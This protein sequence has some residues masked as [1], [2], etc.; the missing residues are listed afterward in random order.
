MVDHALSCEEALRLVHRFLGED[1]EGAEHLALR[2]HLEAC[3]ACHAAYLDAVGTVAALGRAQRHLRQEEEKNTRRA[4]QRRLALAG[5]GE[6]SQRRR[7]NLRILFLPALAILALVQFQSAFG[8]PPR[9]D[10]AVIS[11]PVAMPELLI[12][13]AGTVLPMVRGD[14]CATAPG[15]SARLVVGKTEVHLGALTRVMLEGT[16]PLRL[17]IG[18]GT[19]VLNGPATVTS[20]VGVIEVTSGRARLTYQDEIL[21]AECLSGYLGGWNTEG[22]QKIG[23]GEEAVFYF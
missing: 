10:L 4:T 8:A 17:R 14:W 18:Q 20:P 11:G 3:R 6:R 13:Q 21:R 7:R 16:R 23:A 5:A 19:L 1:G 2:E 22:G 15:A 9:A 12:E